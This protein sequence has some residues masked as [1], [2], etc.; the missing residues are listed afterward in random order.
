MFLPVVGLIQKIW[1]GD[2]AIGKVLFLYTDPHSS[3]WEVDQDELDL[4][5]HR[6]RYNVTH[7][8]AHQICEYSIH[9]W[10]IEKT[11]RQ[12][13]ALPENA[14]I[15]QLKPQGLINYVESTILWVKANSMAKL[16]FSSTVTDM[17]SIFPL[18][19]LYN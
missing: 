6:H 2:K 1:F 4:C 9:Q 13:Q 18:K 8:S 11:L 19:Q 10:G 5:Y 14:A 16:H 17:R 12:L 3:Q 7:V 15:Y